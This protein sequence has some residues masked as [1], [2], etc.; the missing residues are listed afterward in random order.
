[1]SL[2][3]PL[4][5]VR[6]S[7]RHMRIFHSCV[8]IL[9]LAILATPVAPL[10]ATASTE[11]D[12]SSTHSLTSSH[13]HE[14]VPPHPPPLRPTHHNLSQSIHSTHPFAPQTTSPTEGSTSPRPIPHRPPLAPPHR[15][16]HKNLLPIIL[17]VVGSVVGFILLALFTRRAIAFGR[18]PRPS[19]ELT[20]AER[21]QLVR[22]MAEY[23]VTADQHQRQSLA[24][25]PPPPYERAPSYESLRTH[26]PP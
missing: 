25:P 21:A 16:S 22:E 20:A 6:P 23:A 14:A 2:S 7:F 10:P 15:P 5:R 24:V 26:Q 1:M 13:T 18:M 11:D 17:A 8:C 12:P 19:T 4:L 9:S 3:H